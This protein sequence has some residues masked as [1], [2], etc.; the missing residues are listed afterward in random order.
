M[1]P[2]LIINGALDKLVKVEGGELGGRVSRASDAA[3]KPA[4]YQGEFWARANGCSLAAREER[5]TPQLAIWRHACSP[6]LEVVRY[7]VLDGGHGWPKGASGSRRADTPSASL[8]T[9]DVIWDFFRS[10]SKRPR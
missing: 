10:K 4:A 2:A 9:T 3:L 7:L 6:G 5:P 1:A 8:E